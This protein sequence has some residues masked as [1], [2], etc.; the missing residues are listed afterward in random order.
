MLR[1]LFAS[2]FVLLVLALSVN[3]AVGAVALLLA[4]FL[5]RARV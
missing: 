4:Q 1:K 2:L 5:P 3:A